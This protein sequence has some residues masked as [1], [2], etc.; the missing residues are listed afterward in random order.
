METLKR[1]E[2][3]GGQQ[4]PKPGT[5]NP[6]TMPRIVP[7][8]KITPKRFPWYKNTRRK[9][10]WTIPEIEKYLKKYYMDRGVIVSE[11]TNSMIHRLAFN[12]YVASNC[13]KLIADHHFEDVSDFISRQ[14]TA[15]DKIAAGEKSLGITF[16]PIEFKQEKQKP[17]EKKRGPQSI[18]V[19][20]YKNT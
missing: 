3:R 20:K 5:R 19:N 18:N 17:E 8:D 15:M 9:K 1:S 16:K 12:H 7:V 13:Q 4:T 6:D 2:R 10:P 14:N 11:M